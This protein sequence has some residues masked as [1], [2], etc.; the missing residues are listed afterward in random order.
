[1]SIKWESE[2]S[3][4][5]SGSS[6]FESFAAEGEAL[7]DDLDLALVLAALA[8]LVVAVVLVVVFLLAVLLVLVDL[9]LV[10]PVPGVA[11]DVSNLTRLAGPGVEF[12]PFPFVVEGDLVVFSFTKSPD[13]SSPE[14]SDST[15]LLRLRLDSPS[16]FPLLSLSTGLLGL[17][18]VAVGLKP[19]EGPPKNERISLEVILLLVSFSLVI[20]L[21]KAGVRLS[22]RRGHLAPKF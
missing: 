5:S 17:L 10:L 13:S 14:R 7:G 2:A 3:S 21:F 4:A 20:K 11:S 1:M 6:V 15:P 8:V 16:P 12:L 18:E 22:G 9:G 19:K